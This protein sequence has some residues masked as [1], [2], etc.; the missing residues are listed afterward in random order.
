MAE[1][2]SIGELCQLINGYAFK[3]SDWSSEGIPIVRIQNLNN[4]LGKFNYFKGKLDK[5]I[6]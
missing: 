6:I 4:I 1:M 2:E 3:S 5:N